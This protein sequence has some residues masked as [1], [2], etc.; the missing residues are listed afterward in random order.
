MLNGVFMSPLLSITI[1]IIALLS[2]KRVNQFVPIFHRLSVPPA[3]TGGLLFSTIALVIHLIWSISLDFDLNARD[4]LLVYFFTTVGINSRISDLRRGGKSFVYLVIILTIFIIAQNIT[5][6][7]MASMMGLQSSIGLV[8][9]TVSLV[10]GHGVTIAWSP[11]FSD[12]FRLST[13]V[14][15]WKSPVSG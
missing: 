5:G 1:G 2:G 14:N 8:L 12:T 9:G 6:I 3:V 13:T 10:G 15:R 11:S 4:F 7:A